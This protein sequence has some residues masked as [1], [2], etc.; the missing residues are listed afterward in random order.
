[1]EGAVGYHQHSLG[2]VQGVL[3][4]GDE[5]LIKLVQSLRVQLGEDSRPLLSNLFQ[6]LADLADTQCPLSVA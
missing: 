3:D 1:V 5:V 2:V 6:R 4:R